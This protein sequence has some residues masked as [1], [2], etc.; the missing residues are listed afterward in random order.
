MLDSDR[1]LL[2]STVKYF[3]EVSALVYTRYMNYSTS[4]VRLEIYSVLDLCLSN[5]VFSKTI[6]SESIYTECSI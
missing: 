3:L 6:I 1:W 2:L 5:T 4:E